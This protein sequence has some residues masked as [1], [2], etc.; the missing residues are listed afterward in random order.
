M[1]RAS[2]YLRTSPA[3][4]R[5][6]FMTGLKTLGYEC[7]DKL[8]APARGDVLVMWN[9]HRH[10]NHIARQWE[11]R[12]GIVLV[13]E[14]GYIGKDENGG[15]L[16]ALA[17][18]WHNGCGTWNVGKTQRWQTAFH[19]WRSSGDHILVLPQRG[20]GSEGIAMPTGWVARAT[21]ILQTMT[22]RPIRVRA[23]PGLAKTE[24]YDDLKGAW[25]A[26]TWGSGAAIKAL[27]AG[28]PVYYELRNWIGATAST[29][30][31]EIGDIEKPFMGDRLPTFER[32]A[33]AQ[34]SA[35][36]IVSGEAF[37]CLL[38]N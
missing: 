22:R 31:S 37:A 11:E 3:Y 34:W 38:K 7:S 25:A 19:P 1:P 21:R 28:F 20:I 24:P 29:H 6:A 12:G 35:A 17:K 8:F 4:R 26:C 30:I 5:D 18:S 32:L 36:E 9:R 16:F 15:K 27:Y 33:W 10:E 23:H 2:V 14:N 13:A